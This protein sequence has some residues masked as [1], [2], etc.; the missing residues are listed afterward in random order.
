MPVSPAVV[1]LDVS[2]RTQPRGANGVDLGATPG[3]GSGVD[4]LRLKLDEPT[5]LL[6]TVPVP[7]TDLWD[8]LLHLAGRVDHNLIETAVRRWAHVL[9]PAALTCMVTAI[10]LGRPSLWTDELA[11]WGMA[12]T[13]W[14]EFWPV[15]RYVDAVL[16]PYYAF[17]HVWVDAFGDSDISLRTPSLL[18]MVAS[19]GLI[20]AIGQRLSGRA[21]G[22]LA[23]TVFALLASTSRFGAEA[24]PY[25]FAVLGACVATWLLL[26]AWARPTLARWA[27]YA[28]AVA[29]LCWMHVI[30]M[31]LIAAHAWTVLA[32][33]RAL[34]R[35]FA[36]SAAAGV[37]T[38]VLIVVYGVQ[39]RHQVAYIPKM[40]FDAFIPYSEVLFGSVAATGLLI[41]LGLFSLPLRF[42]S[43]VYVAWA[44][45]P[46]VALVAMSIALP[47]FLPRYIAYTTPG[48]ALLAG[49]TLTRMRPSWAII[50]AVMLAALAGPA[51]LQMRGPGGHGQDTREV[52]MVVGRGVQFGDGIV[53]ADDEPLGTWTARDAIA[54]YLPAEYR[55]RDI[56]ATHLPRTGGQLPARECLDTDACVGDT[57]R[58]WVVR[59]GTFD[60]PLAGLGLSKEDIFRAQY[61]IDQVWHPTGMTVALLERK[62]SSP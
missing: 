41:A 12:T 32:W 36:V 54:H 57:Q 38:S 5:A 9:I 20:G 7:A 26:Y 55:P 6:R 46:T 28:F 22:L 44:V 43:A 31:F 4:V 56:L 58:V 42:P 10:G 25:A 19:A 33:K 47:M 49:V 24:R 8:D 48:W 2:P 61:T 29:V 52:A 59:A 40:G 15:L 14:S 34:W 39:Q 53:Y 30:A 45:V 18:A 51:Q 50:G 23:G 35:R 60:D 21:A 27:S 13:P 17:M 16:A 37:V 3:V 1:A 62:P 11:T